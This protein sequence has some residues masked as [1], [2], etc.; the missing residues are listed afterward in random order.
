M[1]DQVENIS[2]QLKEKKIS[3]KKLTQEELK[4][5]KEEEQ[6]D[7]EKQAKI[8]YLDGEFEIIKDGQYVLCAVSGNRI[9]LNDLKYWSVERQEAYDSAHLALIQHKKN[10]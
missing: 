2:D 10:I 4:L 1:T 5:K 6:K 7:I 8:K 3:K 9:N